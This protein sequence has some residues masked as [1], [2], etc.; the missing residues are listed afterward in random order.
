MLY[1][2]LYFLAYFMVCSMIGYIDCWDGLLCGGTGLKIYGG[3]VVGL[4]N[5]SGNVPV[6]L[7]ELLFEYMFLDVHHCLE[8]ELSRYINHEVNHTEVIQKVN[9]LKYN[10]KETIRAIQ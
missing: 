9:Q 1:L 4:C 3:V 8:H 6:D 7:C 2:L 10:M 5:M